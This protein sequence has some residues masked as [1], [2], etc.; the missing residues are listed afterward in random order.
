M[1]EPIFRLSRVSGAPVSDEE[2]IADLR[3]VAKLLGIETMS[4]EQYELH[5]EY[6]RNTFRNR[7]GNWN[8]ALLQSGINISNERD[9]FDDKLIADLCRVAEL[10]GTEK[11]TREQY[12]LH[13]KYSAGVQ[14]NRFGTWN[15][16][17]LRAGLKI[18][19]R[20]DIPDIDLYENILTLWQHYGRQPRRDELAFAPSHISQSPYNHRFGSWMN[21]LKAF[22]DYANENV[23]ETTEKPV[24]E[25]TEILK[26]SESRI[27]TVVVIRHKTGRNP[28]LRLRWRVLQRDNFKC[29]G[30]GAS[31]A[32]TLGVEL[33]VDHIDPWSKGGETVLENLQTL[34]SKCNLGKSNLLP[35]F[36]DLQTT[37]TR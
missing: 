34:C 24:K 3:H 10:L 4:Q 37:L 31:P 29:C 14:Y 33:H 26:I 1:S 28:S 17:L 30:C 23:S 36:V 18:S 13:G 6:S 20:N 15:K 7:F 19:H 8:N 35:E 21:A 12:E 9:I 22:V 25:E 27:E 2:L 11:I 32:I 5:G 16:A